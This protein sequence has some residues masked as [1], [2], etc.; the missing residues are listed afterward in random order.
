MGLLLLGNS[1]S[2]DKIFKAQLEGLLGDRA[3]PWQW[4]NDVL[5]QLADK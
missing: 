5:Y 4:E 1:S 2:A 3:T